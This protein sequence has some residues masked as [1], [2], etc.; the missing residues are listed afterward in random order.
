MSKKLSRNEKAQKRYKELTTR[1]RVPKNEA[2]SMRYWS[3]E[4]Y[5][6]FINR[7]K[8]LMPDILNA[9]RRRKYEEAR[10]LG[11]TSKEANRMK[12]WSAEHF[13]SETA[14]RRK[15]KLA[16]NR[17]RNKGITNTREPDTAEIMII[18]IKE[19]TQTIGEEDIAR[20]IVGAKV[21]SPSQLKRSLKNK[22]EKDFR[23]GGG[24][25]DFRI[26]LVDKN[27]VEK[28]LDLLSRIGFI[29]VYIGD[30]RSMHDLTSA[31]EASIEIIY[32]PSKRDSYLTAIAQTL[33]QMQSP[34]AK[35]NAATIRNEYIGDRDIGFFD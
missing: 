4:R 33:D 16:E 1:Y 20:L 29:V 2:R 32:P 7:R 26:D 22:T 19:V 28:T 30:G 10:A 15:K 5:K 34:T 21:K 13:R 8:K 11:Y 12:G 35:Q 3:D 31:I 23:R 17:K 25:G 9:A 24:I 27:D 14:K 18:S 6:K